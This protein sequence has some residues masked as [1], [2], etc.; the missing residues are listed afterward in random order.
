MSS[1]Q[2][3]LNH[4]YEEINTEDFITQKGMANEIPYFI[5]DYGPEEEI[6]IRDFVSYIINSSPLNAVEI[7]LY[8]VMLEL[9]E[10]EG[11]EVEEFFELEEEEGTEELYASIS[12]TLHDDQYIE[13]IMALAEGAE[14]ILITG[15]GS[16]YPLIRS[17]EILSRLQNVNTR[18]PV[19]LFYPGVFNG[20]QLKLFGKF[21][22]ENYYRVFRIA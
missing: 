5:F 19:I 1:I 13:K 14:I 21:E 20:Y 18:I 12:P 3:R 16:I 7:N 6:L 10:D 4:L 11:V 2:E 15:V 17:H 9:F 8:R 22:T